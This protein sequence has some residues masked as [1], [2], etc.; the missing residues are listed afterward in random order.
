MAIIGL[1]LLDAGV[2]LKAGV[3]AVLGVTGLTLLGLALMS[4]AGAR[5]P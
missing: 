1:C 2:Y 5:A 3:P 4:A